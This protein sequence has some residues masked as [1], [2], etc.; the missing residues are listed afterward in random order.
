LVVITWAV[1]A[2]DVFRYLSRLASIRQ[3]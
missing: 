1:L 3:V 2:E